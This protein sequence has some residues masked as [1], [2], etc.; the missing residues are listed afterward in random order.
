MITTCRGCILK[1]LME[2]VCVS[3]LPQRAFWAM[4]LW[5]TSSKEEFLPLMNWENIISVSE[6]LFHLKL[7]NSQ[8]NDLLEAETHKCG[9]RDLDMQHLF[10][11][12][13]PLQ[14][15]FLWK[16]TGKCRIGHISHEILIDQCGS[17]NCKRSLLV[18]E[19][20]YR[21]NTLNLRKGKASLLSPVQLGLVLSGTFGKRVREVLCRWRK[22][23]PSRRNDHCYCRWEG[24]TQWTHIGF[25]S[26]GSWPC[27]KVVVMLKAGY[28]LT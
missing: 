10:R 12:H 3:C 9:S 20:R 27:G 26:A 5:L 22:D 4:N 23:G 17:Q 1:R 14:Q 2:E 8:W 25:Y 21:K 28:I 18:P 19:G 13:S 16:G 24:M 7:F 6:K 11:C 15:V